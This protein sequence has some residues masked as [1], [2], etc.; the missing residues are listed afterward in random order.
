MNHDINLKVKGADGKA[1]SY[2]F[3]VQGEDE[4]EAR[5]TLASHLSDMS[6]QLGGKPVK[7]GAAKK[8]A[9]PAKAPAKAAA[10][11]TK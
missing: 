8:P 10:K 7:A 6:A 4:A 5:A 1:V 2:G 9:A 3:H 11:K